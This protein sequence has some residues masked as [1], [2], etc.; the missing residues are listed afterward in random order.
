M[1]NLKGF[2]CRESCSDTR[3]PSPIEGSILIFPVSKEGILV[4]M[5]K[6]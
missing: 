2:T 1:P 4:L 6:L 3:D 5:L